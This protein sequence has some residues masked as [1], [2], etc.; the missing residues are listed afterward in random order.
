MEN[1]RWKDPK[2]WDCL[3]DAQRETI[4]NWYEE[5]LENNKK[6]SKKKRPFVEYSTLFGIIPLAVA[7]SYRFF[8]TGI[9]SFLG[10]F[11]C[12]WIFFSIVVAAFSKM[13]REPMCNTRFGYIINIFFKVVAAIFASLLII[14]LTKI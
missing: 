7:Y 13:Y 8:E 4:K 3:D 1:E 10:N 9:L 6:N 2:S 12:S 11:V 5:V 14:S